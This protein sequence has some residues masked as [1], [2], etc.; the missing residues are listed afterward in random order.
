MLAWGEELVGECRSLLSN[1][2]LQ[3]IVTD[4]WQR[5][6]NVWVIVILSMVCIECL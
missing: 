3:D 1:V 4:V 2:T 6:P 5:R